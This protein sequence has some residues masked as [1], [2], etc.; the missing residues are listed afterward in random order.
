MP[1]QFSTARRAPARA[2]VVAHGLTVEALTGDGPLPAGL[3]SGDLGRL[4][5]TAEADQVQVVPAEGRLVVAVGLGPADGV[6][7]AGLRRA[8]ATLARAVR[9]RRSLALDLA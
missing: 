5:F 3:D 6:D 8:S 9:G 1:I 7:P 2:E 4:G